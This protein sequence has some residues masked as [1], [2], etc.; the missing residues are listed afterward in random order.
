MAGCDDVSRTIVVTGTDTDVGKTVFCAGLA[1]LLDGAYW[2]PV[3]A[4]LDG[5]T[6]SE[7]V[8]RLSGL[9]QDRIHPEVWRLRTP[10]SPHWA[11]ELDHVAIDPQALRLPEEKRPL[12]VEG[13]GGL[14]VPL[15]R[16]TLLLGL[17]KIQALLGSSLRPH[18]GAVF[19]A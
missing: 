5:E 12:V 1:Q 10:A 9:G 6:D 2:K 16:R 13:V 3:Q 4:G 7:T 11:A 19:P 18:Q 15:T 17:S 14:M 8:R